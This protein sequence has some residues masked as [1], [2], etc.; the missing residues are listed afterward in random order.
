MRRLIATD[1]PATLTASTC[2]LVF[3]IC[4]FSLGSMSRYLAKRALARQTNVLDRGLREA[5][6]GTRR[7]LEEL[8]P[9]EALN[10]RNGTSDEGFI[11][12]IAPVLVIAASRHRARA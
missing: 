9:I 10:C 1:I 12:S 5:I 8:P 7:E 3:A 4:F 6:A 2:V 11:N